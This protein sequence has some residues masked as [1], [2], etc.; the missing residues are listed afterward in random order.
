MGANDVSFPGLGI[1]IHNLPKSFSV[2]GFEIAMYGVV[3]GLGLVAAFIL[4]LHMAKKEGQDPEMFWDYIIYVVVFGIIG[5]RAYYVIFNWDYYRVSFMRI[6]DI[7]GGGMAIYGSV[8]AGVIT[9]VIYCKLKKKNTFAIMDVAVFGLI[10]GQIMGRYANFFN[11]ECFGDYTGNFLRMYLPVSAVRAEEITDALAAHEVMVGD[12]LCISVHPTFLYESCLNLLVLIGM[13]IYRKHKKFTGEMALF[14]MGG[15]GIVRFF[16]EGL[17][18][19]Q[20]KWFGTNIAVSQAL[21]MILFVVAIAID[22]T[23]RILMAKKEKLQ[24][25]EVKSTDEEE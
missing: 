15:Y 11:R 20:L 5:A 1:T 8:I 16:V 10:L 2:F 7:R 25:V 17:R 19:D 24:K 23:V 4:I 14:Y 12:T 13:I 3:I 18:T 22:V 21:G 6:I 9:T